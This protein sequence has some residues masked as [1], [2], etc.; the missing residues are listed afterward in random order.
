[1]CKEL[2]MYHRSCGGDG[3][4]LCIC[5]KSCPYHEPYFASTCHSVWMN[6][7]DSDRSKQCRNR[8]MDD[9]RDRE[10]AIVPVVACH[11]CPGHKH[12]MKGADLPVPDPNHQSARAKKAAYKMEK[13]ETIISRY[14]R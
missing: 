4:K 14:F 5:D 3:T 2:Y 10:G 9:E 7:D 1:M 12:H 6:T 11:G 13:Q 8:V